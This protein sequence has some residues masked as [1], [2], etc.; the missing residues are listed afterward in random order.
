MNKQEYIKDQVTVVIPVYNEERFLRECLESVVHQVDHVIIGDNASTDGTEAIC[1]EFAEKYNHI[2]YFRNTENLGGSQNFILCAEK[3]DTEFI[4]HLGG[5]DLVPPNYVATLK[6]TLKM[7][8]DAVCAYADVQFI[9]CNGKLFFRQE[10]N[11]PQ[12]Q[13]E[14]G[15]MIA[16]YLAESQPLLR[17]T[18]YI[19]HES[20]AYIIYG[21]YHTKDIIQEWTTFRPVTL[22]DIIVLFNVL[23]KGKFIHS[24]N[25]EFLFRD[26][27]Q[28]FSTNPNE[29]LTNAYMV[30]ITGKDITYNIT[31]EY[32]YGAKIL[33]ECFRNAKSGD[34]TTQERRRL[35]RKLIFF[36]AKKW[37]YYGN[38]EISLYVK[39]LKFYQ[40]IILRY[41]VFYPIAIV[42]RFVKSALTS[43]NKK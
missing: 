30:R 22:C 33:L 28:T 10:F 23:L 7:N 16:P 39:L 8:S 11:N 42:Y 19:L 32:R 3:V 12:S 26:V 41:P 38:F 43:R 5:H 36:C 6:E 40:V 4:F 1:R 27:H 9:D 29:H 2:T 24:S 35:Y 14:W 21:L 18:E 31:A 17:A 20:P 34:L 15:K 13:F 25:T 37:G